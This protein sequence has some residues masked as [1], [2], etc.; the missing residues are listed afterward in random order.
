MTRVK[1]NRIFLY[2]LILCL[3]IV[4]GVWAVPKGAISLD[5]IDGPSEGTEI[6][7]GPITF[8]LR[9]KVD[10]ASDIVK[11][12]ANGFRIYS[13][14]GATWDPITADT[15]GGIADPFDLIFAIRYFSADGA[16][17]DTIGYGGAIFENT[18]LLPGYDQIAFLITIN[19]KTA[20][21]GK[22][23]CIDSAYYRTTGQ[24][25]WSTT[26]GVTYP[27][28]WSGPYCFTINHCLNT[29]D[30]DGDGFRDICDNCPDS[31]NPLQEDGDGDGVGDVCDNCPT[32]SNATQLDADDDGIG[33]IC[34]NCIHAVNVDQLDSDSDS[35]G[36][37]CDNCPSIANTSQ[38]DTD[39]DGVGNVCDN[40]P[41]RANAD[42]A[43]T[44][45]D[46]KGD[47]CD[48]CP[49]FFNPTQLDSDFDGVGDSCDNCPGTFNS[50]QADADSDGVGDVC[51]PCTDSDGDG[52]GDPGYPM[53]VCPP[54]NCYLTYN[55]DQLD[56][57]SN[58]VGD[59]CQTCCVGI[60]GNI[61]GDSTETVDISDLIYLVDYFFA[62]GAEPPCLL[63]A[64]VNGDGAIDVGDIVYLTE[65]MFNNPAGPDP[66]PCHY[67]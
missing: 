28:E 34:D 60:T 45:G 67:Q 26:G 35:V 20:D 55:P 9:V 54:D 11:G 2:L 15:T 29:P 57:D 33:D 38:T 8:N 27:P 18:G 40:C 50:S 24:W 31:A 66:V 47:V 19:P 12:I 52:F 53:N 48:N 21:D 7:T 39:G 43:D 5:H 44:D 49:L 59:I 62:Q 65:Y 61:D 17:S 32:K 23:I 1:S 63:E 37:A 56:V 25:L 13:P 46:G 14:D 3:L 10:S 6:G 16:G 4:G 30:T 51:D 36:D 64:N 22:T 41:N 42:Q 58:G